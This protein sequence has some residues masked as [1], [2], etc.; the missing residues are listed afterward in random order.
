MRVLQLAAISILMA[1]VLVAPAYAWDGH[2]GQGDP[3]HYSSYSHGAG[4]HFSG[5]GGYVNHQWGHH[6]YRPYHYGH[7]GYVYDPI[8]YG[9][10]YYPYSYYAPGFSLSLPGFSF[11]LGY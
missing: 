10:Y 8:Y 4:R 2:H 5:H 3:R 11:S 1:V 6:Y 9:S 7:Y